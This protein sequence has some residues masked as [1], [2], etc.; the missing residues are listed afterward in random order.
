MIGLTHDPRRAELKAFWILL[1]SA[2]LLF[3]CLISA[4]L[5][6]LQVAVALALTITICAI[7]GLIKPRLAKVAYDAWNWFALKV[8][9]V[10]TRLLIRLS[11]IWICLFGLL[12]RSKFRESLLPEEKGVGWLIKESSGA[13]DYFSTWK[14]LNH[15]HS[16]NWFKDSINWCFETKNYWVLGILFH[17]L[18]LRIANVTRK[19]QTYANIYTLF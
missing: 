9:R 17:L 6:T 4:L 11:H 2:L 7:I 16:K 8:S 14:A 18:L 19:D 10:L 5:A 3:V 1:T 12:L 13:G 15:R